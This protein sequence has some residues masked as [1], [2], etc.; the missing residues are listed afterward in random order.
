[1]D[2]MRLLEIAAEAK[3][4]AEQNPTAE[5]IAAAA[6]ALAEYQAA[7]AYDHLYS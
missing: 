4:V 1:M 2:K 5:N 7:V 3:K 6:A